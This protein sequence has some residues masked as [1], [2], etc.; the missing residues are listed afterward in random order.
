[1][2]NFTLTLILIAISPLYFFSQNKFATDF[3]PIRK[4]LINWDE[5]R[6]EWLATS[7]ESMVYNQ[8]IPSRTFHEDF[9]PGEMLRMVPSDKRDV[10]NRQIETN[11]RNSTENSQ[12]NAWK[13]LKT[14]FA[15]ANCKPVI[16]RS[17]GDPHLTSFDGANYSFQTVGEF[18]L[19]KSNSGKFEVQ[20]RQ[21][22]QQS[23][24]SLNSAVALNVGGDR[25][26]LYPNEKPDRYNN[27]II[28]LNGEPITIENN[29]YFLPKGGTIRVSKR[30][31]YVDWPSG[32][33]ATFHHS[34]S[35]N[36]DFLNVTV[37]IYPCADEEFSGLLGNA[38]RNMSDDFNSRTRTPQTNF[39][40]M[41]AFNN[42]EMNAIS[43][44]VEREQL[45]YIAKDF[46][47]EWRVTPSTTLF[48]YG[49][50]E[51]TYTFTDLRFPMVHRT[52]RDLNPNQRDKARNICE[53][54]GL[55]DAELR[56]CIFDQGF[57]NIE[58]TR[59][60]E[61]VDRTKDVVLTKVE[62]TPIKPSTPVDE[63]VKPTKKVVSDEMKSNEN[64]IDKEDKIEKDKSKSK[65]T[66]SEYKPIFKENKTEKVEKTQP[67]KT[68]T[69]KEKPVKTSTPIFNTPVKTN[70]EKSNPIKTTSPTTTPVKTTPIKTSTPTIKKG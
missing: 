59:K 25:V 49:I 30:N 36:M 37:Q 42:D 67:I 3:E 52:V 21:R 33:T 20:S 19:S 54:Q 61:V 24:F 34:R 68:N 6:G 28:R 48:D 27:T 2:K 9:T 15:K 17:Y 65:N 69:E 63:P 14:I 23:D 26:C 1:M 7:L 57:L 70:M 18:V 66:D 10:L 35:G 46:A 32:E 22:A 43:E 13:E 51:S 8:A 55:R 40:S 29:T 45:A 4:E 56:A 60:P 11:L 5:V 62:R 44:Q 38:N 39:I 12:A 41:M 16:G 31:Y 47:A 53:Q 50:G 58:P 64:P